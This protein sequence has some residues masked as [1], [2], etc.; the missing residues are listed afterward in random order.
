[1]TEQIVKAKPVLIVTRDAALCGELAAILLQMSDCRLV[2]PDADALAF[3]R[4]GHFEHGLVVI[5]MQMP[6]MIDL[7][8]LEEINLQHDTLGAVVILRERDD[9]SVLRCLERGA[10]DCL[11]R[12]F[13]E[14]MVSD[15][16]GRAL[17][18]I[19]RFLGKTEVFSV[20]IELQ[21]WIEL[22]A[23]TDFEYV[24]RFQRFTSLLGNAP[25]REEDKRHIR[26]A[27]DEIGQNA[28]E[29]GN[30]RDRHK[31][32]RLSYCIFRDRLVFK[33]EDEGKGFDTETLRDPSVDP[34]SHIAKRAA[35]GKRPG[36]YGIFLT[37]KLMDDLTF[38]DRGNIVVMTKY[39]QHAPGVEDGDEH[40]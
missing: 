8:L 34:L 2:E 3:L 22:T 7:E 13:A 18:R 6:E 27:I 28:V 10:L 39:F 21:G 11:C 37:R 26:I 20:D 19:D 40:A 23:P 24:E 38:N 12:P 1:M 30:R 33:V 15:V 5:D 31:Q 16:I 17:F 4:A 29:W 9:A 25:L 32:I 36:G 14:T 35:E